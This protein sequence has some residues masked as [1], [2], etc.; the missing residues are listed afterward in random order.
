MA[1]FFTTPPVIGHKESILPLIARPSQA[2]Q[3]AA[4]PMVMVICA[5]AQ[6]LKVQL[7]SKQATEL[8]VQLSAKRASELWS[9]IWKFLSKAEA[10]DK[11]GRIVQYFC[12]F[13]QGVI[14]HAPDSNL[15]P[16][17]P[18]I[19]E[20]QTTLAWARRTHRWGKEMPHIPVL[21]QAI[22]KGDVLEASQRAVLVT[23]LV[24][25]HIY[26]LLKV[27]L[28]KFKSYTAVEWHRRNLRFITFSHVLNFSLCVREIARIKAKQQDN[29]PKYTGS[30]EALAKADNEIYDNKRMMFR[31]VLTFIQMLSVSQVRKMDDRM[32]G[33]MGCVSSYIDASK[34]W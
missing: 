21:G 29:D 33:L 11:V 8:W 19:A 23:F 10:R 7:T 2:M 18:A 32:V 28:L 1:P 24:Q 30:E 27:G 9:H 5:G 34:Q 25:D 15:L 14:E 22:C 4:G 26:W 3:L 16:W 6:I 17:K 13:L 20:I 12:R 31:Y